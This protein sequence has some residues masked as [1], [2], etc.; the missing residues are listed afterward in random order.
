MNS[1]LD[2]QLEHTGSTVFQTL[3]G[4]WLDNGVADPTLPKRD[5]A[6]AIQ[7]LLYAF[8]FFNF[9]QL[10]SL[11]GLR[12]LDK[13]RRGRG[14]LP[15]CPE[16]LLSTPGHDPRASTRNNSVASRTTLPPER[17]P[18]LSHL[19]SDNIPC[20]P[21]HD[22]R[23][24]SEKRRGYFFAWLSALL[25]CTAWVIFLHTAWLRLRSKEER[26]MWGS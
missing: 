11:E 5:N 4:I 13:R 18:L 22:L 19:D 20:G 6:L 12:Y 1:Y 8:L 16:D 10:I 2:S 7:H 23:R 26:G 3:A 9:L 25:I 21:A 17:M 14:L 24:R 15:Y